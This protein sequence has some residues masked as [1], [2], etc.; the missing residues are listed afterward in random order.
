MPL[1]QH[2]WVFAGEVV[3]P[4]TDTNNVDPSFNRLEY[5]VICGSLRIQFGQIWRYWSSNVT[6]QFLGQFTKI[7]NNVLKT[8]PSEFKIRPPDRKASRLGR[9]LTDLMKE[10]QPNIMLARLLKKGNPDAKN[11]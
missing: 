5:C 6:K 1:H 3:I 8:P 10:E 7:S 2:Q 11:N 9:N 4:V